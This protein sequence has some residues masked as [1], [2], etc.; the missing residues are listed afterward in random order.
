VVARGVA[1]R[2]GGEDGHSPLFVD[3]PL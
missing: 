1:L 2:N 3:K